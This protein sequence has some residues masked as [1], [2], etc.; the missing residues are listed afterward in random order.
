MGAAYGV[1]GGLPASIVDAIAS[2]EPARTRWDPCPY[3]PIHDD[4]IQGQVEALLGAATV[5]AI[6]V[7]WC[8]D[9][10]VSVQDMASYVGELMGVEAR[11]EVTPVQWASLG[12][13]GDC[14][15]RMGIT[16]P[17]RVHWRD[18]LRRMIEARYPN[19]LVPSGG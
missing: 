15:K 7:N 17:G 9:N 5:P 16:G 19:R 18:G 10:P 1:R 6:I 12:S 14:T 13:V 4:D 2:G 3:S 11:V 8:G